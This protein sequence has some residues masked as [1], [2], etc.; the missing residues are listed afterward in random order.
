MRYII[1]TFTCLFFINVTIY[2]TC[3]I[4]IEYCKFECSSKFSTFIKDIYFKYLFILAVMMLFTY[5]N[6]VYLGGDFISF[7]TELKWLLSGLYVHFFIPLFIVIDFFITPRRKVFNIYNDL[8][9]LF[10]WIGYISFIIILAK[11]YEV[12]LYPFLKSLSIKYIV[13]VFFMAS[14]FGFLFNLFYYYWISHH[15]SPKYTIKHCELEKE[16]I[17]EDEM[18]TEQNN[19]YNTI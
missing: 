7:S 2:T 8:I 3:L 14:V 11:Q 18:F 9:F 6:L 12:Y 1:F 4:I 17:C 16:K 13:F 10:I 5:W 15:S 19:S